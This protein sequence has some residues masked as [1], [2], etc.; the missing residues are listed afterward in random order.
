MYSHVINIHNVL[1]MVVIV[2]WG[3]SSVMHIAVRLSLK[4]KV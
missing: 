3:R 4:F 1:F 2:D